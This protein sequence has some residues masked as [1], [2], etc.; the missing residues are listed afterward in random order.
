VLVG[1]AV[2]GIDGHG[3][4][5]GERR[6]PAR[7]VLWAAGVAASPLA[8]S[9][10][11]PL[12]R[13]GRV[14]VA[15]DLS[16]PGY[17]EVLVIGDL[18]ALVEDGRPVPGVAPA[19]MQMGRHAARNAVRKLRGQPTLPFRYRDKGSL[20]TIGRAAAVAE[21]GRVKL[22]GLIAWLAWLAIHIFFLIGF[23]NRFLVIAEWAWVYLRN[24]RG[25]R[26]ITGDVHALLER[27]QE[28]EREVE[29][30]VGQKRRP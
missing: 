19:A 4:T 2:T 10:G 1:S 11:V 26:L 13:A 24:D 5:L 27:P 21:I 14:K 22:S 3:V 25:A 6:L 16:V 29:R 28:Q 7:T 17:P 15:P 9:L 23:R 8:R 20:A 12:D 30:E 18:A